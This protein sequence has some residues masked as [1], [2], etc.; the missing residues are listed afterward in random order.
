MTCDTWHSFGRKATWKENQSPCQDRNDR[1]ADIHLLLWPVL[2]NT[3]R[4]SEGKWNQ[5]EIHPRRK[6][7]SQRQLTARFV[8]MIN[9][10]KAS[11]GKMKRCRA[12]GHQLGPGPGDMQ[13]SLQKV[14]R[15]RVQV[16]GFP[17]S[18]HSQ[19]HLTGLLLSA[20]QLS[21]GG[22]ASKEEDADEEERQTAGKKGRRRE[23]R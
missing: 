5:K 20:W 8:A 23:W 15:G 17:A 9:H 2:S 12:R 21:Q 3:C 10:Q 22:S 19:V 13:M 14:R 18:P 4:R 16:L 1:W 7:P 6:R 11:L